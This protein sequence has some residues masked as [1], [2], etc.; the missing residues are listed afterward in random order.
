VK[1][2]DFNSLSPLQTQLQALKSQGCILLRS[3]L[4]PTFLI[5][6][7]SELAELY[8]KAEEALQ[9]GR[10]P[11]KVY[12]RLYQYGHL[13]PESL[14]SL[15]VFA[16]TVLQSENLR[17]L[18]LAIF[19]SKLALLTKGTLPRRQHPFWPERSIP[20]H[21][22]AEFLAGISALNFWLPL[23]TCGKDAPGL[24][25]LLQPQKQL[26]FEL[27]PEHDTPL[28][29]HR[30]QQR[31][32]QAADK[33]F[34]WRPEMEIGDLLIFDSYLLHRTHLATSMFH[35]RYSFEIRLTHPTQAHYLPHRILLL[36]T[37]K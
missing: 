37:Q 26:W 14:L 22:D 30:D 7:R 25:L 34:F 15:S 27:N 8:Q 36:E 23:D 20:F 6:L 33:T 16:D 13:P 5:A 29:L 2:P 17:S 28:Y 19:G 12:Q 24:E 32:L 9:A 3:C 21:Q 11:P 10:M 31:V 1:Y 18:L 4:E 35:E